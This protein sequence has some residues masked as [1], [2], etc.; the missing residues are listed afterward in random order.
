[1]PNK[2]LI[3]GPRA[4]LPIIELKIGATVKLYDNPET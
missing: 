3:L 2:K 4:G 1:M